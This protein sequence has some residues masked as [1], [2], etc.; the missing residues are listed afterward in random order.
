M[1]ESSFQIPADYVPTRV[2][3][4]A[5]GLLTILDAAKLLDMSVV[6][7]AQDVGGDGIEVTARFNNMPCFSIQSID[8]YRLR[9]H[10]RAS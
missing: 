4:H 5:Q 9:R 7:L 8:D 2:Q 1:C 10:A 3:A 6:D